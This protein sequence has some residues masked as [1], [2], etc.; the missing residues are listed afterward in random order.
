MSQLVRNRP[1]QKH[2]AVN[3][4]NV[5]HLLHSVHVD[6]GEQPS[7]GANVDECIAER[8]GGAVVPPS[9]S[10]C[11]MNNKL[12][13]RQNR[14]AR[15]REIAISPDDVDARGECSR[16]NSQ[17]IVSGGGGNLRGVVEPRYDFS[18]GALIGLRSGGGRR[19]CQCC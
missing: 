5:R 18:S 19:T 10:T 2:F 3:L 16:C 4:R 6:R 12:A 13:G 8:K 1:S 17:G 15:L 11:Q 9:A 14:A 7:P